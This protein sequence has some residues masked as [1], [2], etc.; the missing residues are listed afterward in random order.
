MTVGPI[1]TV[2]WIGRHTP[3]GAGVDGH[4]AAVIA[5]AQDLLLRDLHER[6]SLD[7]LVFKGGTSL[8]KLY[9]GNQGRFSLDLDFSVAD[10]ISDPDTVVLELV[11]DIDGT[12]IGPFSY[13]VTERRGKWSLTIQSPFGTDESTLSS[14][15]DISPPPWLEPVR[16]GWVGMP[17]NAPGARLLWITGKTQIPFD[18]TENAKPPPWNR[19]AAVVAASGGEW[20]FYVEAGDAGTLTELMRALRLTTT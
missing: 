6:G 9:A 4:D 20:T 19:Y 13:G 11:N 5:I 2:G 16:R 7:A 18:P 8:R 15:L 1:M 17:I 14:K 10:P 3:R 12:T